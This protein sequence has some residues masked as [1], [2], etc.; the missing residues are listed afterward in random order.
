MHLRVEGH[1]GVTPRTR[2]QPNASE[3]MEFRVAPKSLALGWFLKRA[4]KATVHQVSTRGGLVNFERFGAAKPRSLH[5]RGRGPREP[6]S[7]ARSSSRQCFSTCSATQWVHMQ[8]VHE[9]TVYMGC[10]QTYGPVLGPGAALCRLLKRIPKRAPTLDKP[11][12]LS[13]QHIQLCVCAC[14][15][16]KEFKIGGHLVDVVYL[17]IHV[18]PNLSGVLH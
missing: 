18:Q 13:Y 1:C 11:Y 8:V 17:R 9:L 3:F 5:E 16:L 4:T 10:C 14:V 15:G 2:V 12:V 7:G 6:S